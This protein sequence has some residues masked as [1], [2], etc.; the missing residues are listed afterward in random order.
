VRR[1]SLLQENLSQAM[2]PQP[3]SVL[4]PRPLPSGALSLMAGQYS[5]AEGRARRQKGRSLAEAVLVAAVEGA[6]WSPGLGVATL[7]ALSA[8]S[9]ELSS[10]AALVVSCRPSLRCAVTREALTT[11]SSS[12]SRVEGSGIGPS[13]TQRF[14]SY[15]VRMKF[16][17][18]ASEGTWP[19]ASFASQYL[20]ARALPHFSTLC[21]C[22]SVQVSRSTDLTLLICVP[23]PRCMPEHRMQMK[24]PRF[25]LAHLG[26]TMAISQ[27][28]SRWHTVYHT[29]V[30]LA[31]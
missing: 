15:F 12:A 19:G 20:F 4:V 17:I 9:P 10:G 14:D 5:V 31:V 7:N 2:N 16:S 13:M 26:S 28:A 30:P 27:G 18:L 3:C 21:S 23:I 1:K 24:T 22:S 6:G 29:L 11:S 25:Q 8:P